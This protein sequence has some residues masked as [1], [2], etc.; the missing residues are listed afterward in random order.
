MFGLRR[1]GHK[2]LPTLLAA[3][4]QS[5]AGNNMS[6]DSIGLR[7]RNSLKKFAECPHDKWKCTKCGCS[8]SLT[9]LQMP[10]MA[11]KLSMAL[12]EIRDAVLHK[13]FQLAEAG[14]DNDQINAVLGIIDDLDPRPTDEA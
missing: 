2:E 3:N 4:K 6:E 12:D 5:G 7:L 11:K 10:S 13:R 14:L 8:T 1:D 9:T